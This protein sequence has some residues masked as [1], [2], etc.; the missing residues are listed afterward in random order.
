LLALT[1]LTATAVPALAQDGLAERLAACAGEAA[2]DA[3]LSCF[4]ALAAQGASRPAE[5]PPRPAEPTPET[6]SAPPAAEAPPAPGR[7]VFGQVLRDAD[8]VIASGNWFVIRRADSMT[9][10]IRVSLSNSGE[11]EMG[12]ANERPM[13]VLRC[14][15]G[16]LEAFIDVGTYIGSH[17]PFPIR[18]RFDRA[19][20]ETQTWS[21]SV[22]GKSIFARDPRGFAERLTRSERLLVEVTAFGGRRYRV[23]FDLVGIGDVLPEVASCRRPQQRQQPR[24]GR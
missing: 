14:F 11:M 10:Q 23:A 3:R 15:R 24:R 18:L 1:L 17:Q 20:A 12:E 16:A 22:T 19:E 21:P 2:E 5:T 13:L 6:A 7:G 9:D 4:D 8:G